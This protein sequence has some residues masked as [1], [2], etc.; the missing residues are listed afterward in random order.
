MKGKV[1]ALAA[2]L[3]LAAPSAHAVTVTLNNNLLLDGPLQWGSWLFFW[4]L[5]P[6]GRYFVDPLQRSGD[7]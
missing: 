6:G 4:K 2:C 1:L 5:H 3:I 7:I